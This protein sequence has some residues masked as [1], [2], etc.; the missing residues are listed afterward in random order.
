MEAA[1][2]TLHS[3]GLASTLQRAS[4]LK[5]LRGRT[6]HPDAE[7]VYETVHARIPSISLDTVYRTLNLFSKRGLI[8]QLAVPTHRFR[9]DGC[10]HEHDHFLCTRCER[11]EDIPRGAG[12][13]IAIP[14]GLRN[15]GAVQAVQRVYLGT[16]RSCL[17][18]RTA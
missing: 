17:E 16:C 6:D 1:Q 10:V 2:Q 8:A 18:K 15:I 4:I 12:A 11:I 3:S 7:M 13:T 9:F 14:N 5:C